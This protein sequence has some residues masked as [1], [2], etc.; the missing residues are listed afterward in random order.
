VR[1]RPHHV[2]FALTVIIT[3]A[4]A[5]LSYEVGKQTAAN[6][7]ATGQATIEWRDRGDGMSSP[8]LV[9]KETPK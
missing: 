9:W 7:V 1:L 2:H 4:I 5:V 8:R 6:A 3:L